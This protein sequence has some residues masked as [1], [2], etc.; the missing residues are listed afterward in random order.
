MLVRKL[1]LCSASHEI[2]AFRSVAMLE[3]MD[4]KNCNETCKK[5]RRSHDDT[6]SH[7]RPSRHGAGRWCRRH[8]GRASP[9]ASTRSA[10]ANCPGRRWYNDRLAGPLLARSEGTA[11]AQ[12]GRGTCADDEALSRTAL[13]ARQY[14]TREWH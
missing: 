11:A 9:G 14:H 4:L 6:S 8:S 5:G 12:A 2:L 1:A 10:H 7:L 3:V 13:G